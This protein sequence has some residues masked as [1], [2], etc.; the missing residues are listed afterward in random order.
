MPR[1]FGDTQSEAFPRMKSPR[2]SLAAL[3]TAQAQE[4]FNDCAA[5]MMLGALAQQLA[6][7]SGADSKPILALIAVLPD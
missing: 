2:A 6:R 5:K 7:A 1:A 4:P 3:W